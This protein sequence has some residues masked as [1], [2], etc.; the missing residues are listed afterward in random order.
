M[1]KNGGI[2]DWRDL[3]KKEADKALTEEKVKAEIFKI[4]HDF[5]V[6]TKFN[7]E[8]LNREDYDEL[9]IIF[10][11]SISAMQILHTII[12]YRVFERVDGKLIKYMQNIS[13]KSGAY[14]ID[15]D[16][17]QS[18]IEDKAVDSIVIHTYDKMTDEEYN[19]TI[20]KTLSKL[21]MLNGG[22]F[23]ENNNTLSMLNEADRTLDVYAH[24]VIMQYVAIS[25]DTDRLENYITKDDLVYLCNEYDA[26]IQNFKVIEQNG[27]EINILGVEDSTSRFIDNYS[28]KFN[29]N[30]AEIIKKIG[31][32]S[33]IKAVKV[34]EEIRKK[35]CKVESIYDID[36]EGNETEEEIATEEIGLPDDLALAFDKSAGQIVKEGW[37]SNADKQHGIKEI[38]TYMQNNISQKLFKINN[39]GL[40]KDICLKIGIRYGNNKAF[41]KYINSL[42]NKR[43]NS[44]ELFESTDKI[45]DAY[46]ILNYAY[47]D[48][49]EILTEAIY[50]LVNGIKKRGF[51]VSL[52]VGTDSLTDEKITVINKAELK[53]VIEHMV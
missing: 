9:E 23:I 42:S 28:S 46:E 33:S 41:K 27:N 26:C 51:R 15:F 36:D 22:N 14:R 8:R 25:S 20:E 47:M 10:E 29:N 34:L 16:Y 53:N 30:L 2:I 3:M 35:A 5:E 38:S 31:I 44:L 40:S 12:E 11:S 52:Q 24:R 6:D 21:K 1:S 18:Q 32:D 39:G 48:N 19:E 50:N 13:N 49:P 43:R 4:A 45:T 17:L 37:L 7:T